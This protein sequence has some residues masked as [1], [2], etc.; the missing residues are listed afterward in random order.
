MQIKIC[1]LF[2]VEDIDYVNEAKPDYVGFVFAKSKRQ[3]DIHQAEKLKNKLDSNIKAVGVFVDEQISEITA[4]V[5]MGIIDLIQ[6]HGHEDNAYIKQLKQSVQMPIIKA[7]KVI[8]KD[9]L[10]NLDYE[11]DYYLLDS[12]ISGSGK[13]FDWSLIKDL[14]KPFFLA[15]G[16]DLDNLDEQTTLQIT[17]LCGHYTYSKPKVAL[18]INKLY[19]NLASIKIDGKRFVIEKLK[20]EMQKH[21]RC[22]NMEGLTSKMLACKKG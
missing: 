1:G 6:L 14:D 3:V 15:G 13:S 19:E 9:D 2:Q 12:K 17:E 7:I 11:C 21:V 18:E 16:I 22:F 4:I 10:N 5:K 20:E 8:E